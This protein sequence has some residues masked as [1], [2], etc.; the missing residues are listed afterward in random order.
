MNINNIL[1]TKTND[2]ENIYETLDMQR[3]HKYG[4]NQT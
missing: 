4:K 2:N 3:M 1:K